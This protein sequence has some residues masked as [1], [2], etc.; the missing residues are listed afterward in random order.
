MFYWFFKLTFESVR[1]SF[2]HDHHYPST[3][4]WNQVESIEFCTLDSRQ[5]VLDAT[6][7]QSI[8]RISRFYALHSFLSI[9]AN[10]HKMRNHN[11]SNYRVCAPCESLHLWLCRVSNRRKKEV[12]KNE[13]KPRGKQTVQTLQSLRECYPHSI[14]LLKLWCVV[15]IIDFSKLIYYKV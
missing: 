9:C 15:I 8:A 10:T 5:C 11:G 1:R 13:N 4:T 12:I 6:S 7:R 3:S 2:S 14:A